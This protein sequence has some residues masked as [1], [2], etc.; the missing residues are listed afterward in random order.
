MDQSDDSDVLALGTWYIFILLSLGELNEMTYC[1][2]VKDCV[3]LIFAFFSVKPL[4]LD[5]KIDFP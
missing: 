4:A 5:A 3:S 1:K 2:F